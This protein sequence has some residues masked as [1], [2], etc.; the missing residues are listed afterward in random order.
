MRTKVPVQDVTLL[1]TSL[2]NVFLRACYNKSH[3]ILS[4]IGQVFQVKKFYYNFENSSNYSPKTLTLMI[5]SL[6]QGSNFETVSKY[7][8]PSY[9]FYSS[10]VITI[11]T[12]S[13]FSKKR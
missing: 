6:Y 5:A 10:L 7:I 2:V 4:N 11:N 3:R 12:G 1:N 8:M 9:I 13:Y